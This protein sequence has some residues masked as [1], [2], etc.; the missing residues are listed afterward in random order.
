MAT[1][2]AIIITLLLII[3]SCAYVIG[4]FI[5]IVRRCVPEEVAPPRVEAFAALGLCA[6]KAIVGPSLPSLLLPISFLIVLATVFAVVK[7]LRVAIASFEAPPA[8]R[9]IIQRWTAILIPPVA[10]I[11]LLGI[12]DTLPQ[13]DGQAL[14]NAFVVVNI[15][16][17][18]YAL[19]NARSLLGWR[20]SA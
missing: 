12:F 3:T 20:N 7:M 9:A 17:A 18:A 4:L 2:V 16:P 5:L 1:F 14:I 11:G 13:D 6:A 10:S 15:I 19:I 8:A